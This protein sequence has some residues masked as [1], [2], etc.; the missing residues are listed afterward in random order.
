[1]PLTSKKGPAHVTPGAGG[2]CPEQT[3]RLLWAGPHLPSSL[4]CTGSVAAQG[5][6]HRPSERREVW[7][8]PH[9]PTPPQVFTCSGEAGG[10]ALQ[11]SRATRPAVSAPQTGS[12]SGGRD[13]RVAWIP[14][15][16][17]CRAGGQI[18]Q[19]QEGSRGETASSGGVGGAQGGC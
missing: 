7:T 17:E 19:G 14:C 6:G 11:G 18:L 1:M 13:G 3:G 5:P 4:V 10:Q 2:S 8:S 16:W 9:I 15:C 12:H